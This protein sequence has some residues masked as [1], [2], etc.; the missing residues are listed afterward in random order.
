MAREQTYAENE[1]LIKGVQWVSTLDDKTS[2]VCRGRDGIVYESDRGPRPPAHP[3]CRSTTTP[4]L[5]SWKELGINLKEAP[6]GTRAS[7]N[8]QVPATETYNSWLK[9]QPVEFQDDVLGPAR[10]KLYRKGGVSMDKFTD[11]SGD[12][13]TLKQLRRREA[14]A[15]KKAEVKV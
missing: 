11:A 14:A 9:K 5:K 10:G 8:G 12:Q 6:A 15:F 3:N 7:L 1:D 2:P 4:V 13:Y